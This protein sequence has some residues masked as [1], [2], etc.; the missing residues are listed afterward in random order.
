MFKGAGYSGYQVVTVADEET[1]E[2]KDQIRFDSMVTLVGN[3]S[4]Y[5][6]VESA[7]KAKE[8]E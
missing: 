2:E 8:A 5:H 7:D 6:P 4:A 3:K 1:K